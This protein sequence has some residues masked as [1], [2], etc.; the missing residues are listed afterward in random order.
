M[1]FTAKFH[2]KILCVCGGVGVPRPLSASFTRFNE[3]STGQPGVTHPLSAAAA[4]TFRRRRRRLLGIGTWNRYSI[5]RVQNFP[6]RRICLTVDDGILG[7]EVA[8][9]EEQ[10]KRHD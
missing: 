1:H 3:P 9:T 7:A 8:A 10:D 5:A 6:R 2:L 4:A